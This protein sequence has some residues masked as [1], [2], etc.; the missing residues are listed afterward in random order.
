MSVDIENAFGR[1]ENTLETNEY[2]YR[3]RG[4]VA[5]LRVAF[6]LITGLHRSTEEVRS[7]ILTLEKAKKILKDELDN[8]VHEPNSGRL[9]DES[10]LTELEN[11]IDTFRLSVEERESENG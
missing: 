11:L 3:L 9:Q 7:F 8:K 4:E 1:D 6:M 10:T 2:L 5:G